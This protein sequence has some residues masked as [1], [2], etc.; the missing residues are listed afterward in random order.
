MKESQNLQKERDE[1]LVEFEK[2]RLESNALE[3]QLK[4]LKNL[5]EE[6][7]INPADARRSR[8][9]DSPNSRFGTPEM[10]RLRD[11]EQQ[12]DASLKAHDEMRSTFEVQQSAVTKEWEDRVAAL[13]NDHQAAVKY[14]RGTEKM[15]AKM[16]QE[17]DRYKAANTKLEEQLAESRQRSVNTSSTAPAEWESQR[18]GLQKEQESLKQN[19][20]A[21]E[22]RVTALQ[23]ELQ[24]AH[25]AREA[26]AS[27][28]SSLE[29]AS[30]Q[31]KADLESLRREN[32]ALDE[33]ARDAEARVQSFLDQFETSVD[34]YRRQSLIPPANGVRHTRNQDSIAGSVYSNDEST[35][36]ENLAVTTNSG[37][38][39]RNSL[40]L[41]NL[42]TE[43]D[44][45]RSQWETTNKNYRLSDR[46]DFEKT[47]TS[48]SFST[49]KP[50]AD[51]GASNFASPT[52]A[53]SKPTNMI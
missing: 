43:L 18:E 32:T 33:R 52:T 15:L 7:G 16:K 31:S 38:L 27:Q 48:D 49:W 4:T 28:L 39:D 1:M 20:G 13:S 41:D 21:L 3:I 6:R 11:L 24:E 9:L 5:L 34:N 50:T 17:L 37:N 14:L 53:S 25:K 46:F 47:P 30:T 22:G 36:D 51:H 44:A 35:H 10:T 45:L 26:A 19:V 12:L 23:S 2:H 40:A 29:A 42:A 8:G